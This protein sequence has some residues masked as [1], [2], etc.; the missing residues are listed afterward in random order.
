MSRDN[1]AGALAPSDEL[2]FTVLGR[3]G[4][5]T[6]RLKAALVDRRVPAV[7]LEDA[8]RGDFLAV[9]VRAFTDEDGHPLRW[10]TSEPG[11]HGWERVEA[12]T[13][14]D[15][16]SVELGCVI[17]SPA[18]LHSPTGSEPTSAEAAALEASF[19]LDAFTWFSPVGSE[20]E[21]LGVVA[22]RAG[23]ALVGRAAGAGAVVEP[24]GSPD[25]VYESMAWAA[26]GA[27]FL[28]RSGKRRGAG[29]ASKDH[30]LVIHWWDEEWVSVDPSNPWDMDADGRH[31]RDWLDLLLPEAETEPWTDSF[32]SDG[33][34]LEELRILLRS[35]RSDDATFDRLIRAVGLP[36]LL[37]DVASGRVAL[38]G[39]DGATIFEPNTLWGV[40]KD[41]VKAEA[42][43]PVEYPT[44]ARPCAVWEQHRNRRSPLYLALSGV[45]LGAFVLSV[46]VFGDDNGLLWLKWVALAVIVFDVLRPRKKALE[47]TSGVEA[48]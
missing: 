29:F 4:N 3:G 24:T 26:D 31:V 42:K 18:G 38:A 32:R 23:Q 22:K 13:L 28:A 1:Q 20:I 11:R 40:V 47:D 39:S 44:W 16:L 17:A 35:P 6:A 5:F 19:S 8:Q 14:F 15:E 9:A 2:S 48:P 34:N 37:A 7:V 12:V 46:V 41:A 45:A 33:G 25:A 43:R 30:P 36:P 27:L 21:V 10:E